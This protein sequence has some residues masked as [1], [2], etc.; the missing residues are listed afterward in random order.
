MALKAFN[1]LPE[2]VRNRLTG[3][4]TTPS[5]ST[6]NQLSVTKAREDL[7]LRLRRASS[8]AGS[9]ITGAGLLK[10]TLDISQPSLTPV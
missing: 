8:R 3:G 6:V 1:L 2:D 10:S 7:R 4:A 5:V 9:N